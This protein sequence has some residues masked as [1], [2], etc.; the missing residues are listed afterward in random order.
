MITGS[1]HNKDKKAGKTGN[2]VIDHPRVKRRKQRTFRLSRSK[3]PLL[4]VGLLL[5]Y[6]AFSLGSRFDSLYSMQRDLQAIQTE[7]QELR[8]INEE[9]KTQLQLLQSDAYIEQVA[10]DKLGLVKP[11]ETRI[12]TVPPGATGAP[13]DAGEAIIGD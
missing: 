4:V 9:L 5:F 7:V 10:R 8:K 3:L 2:N 11:G 13:Q 6:V 12:V 1:Q